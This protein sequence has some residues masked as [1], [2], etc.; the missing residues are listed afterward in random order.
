MISFCASL[1]IGHMESNGKAQ[2]SPIIFTPLIMNLGQL[3]FRSFSA[4]KTF[5]LPKHKF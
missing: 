5:V 2:T 4:L 3:Q 1:C